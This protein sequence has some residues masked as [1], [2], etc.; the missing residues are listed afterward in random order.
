KFVTTLVFFACELVRNN[1]FS[2]KH[3]SDV[4]E[5]RTETR[6]PLKHRRMLAVSLCRAGYATGVTRGAGGKIRTHDS[7]AAPCADTL[8]SGMDTNGDDGSW[9][10]RQ[11]PSPRWQSVFSP[12]SAGKLA[13]FSRQFPVTN[14]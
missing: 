8:A 4:P 11:L 1:A 3:L 14:Q 5:N 10:K 12:T 6:R 9:I 7:T 13:R 2:P